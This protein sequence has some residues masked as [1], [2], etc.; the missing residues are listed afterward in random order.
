MLYGL[1]RSGSIE[2]SSNK[3][4][5]RLG[6]IHACMRT[7]FQLWQPIVSYE[8]RI[9]VSYGWGCSS[10]LLVRVMSIHSRQPIGVEYLSQAFPATASIRR[11]SRTKSSI[12]EGP[13]VYFI[14][15]GIFFFVL[16]VKKGN[17]FFLLKKKK[18]NVLRRAKTRSSDVW[19]DSRLAT[20]RTDRVCGSAPNSLSGRPGSN[21]NASARG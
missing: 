7:L 12:E 4:L 3:S 21:L 9:Y 19:Q 5:I 17:V 8:T 15:A 1:A 6:C 14:F 10:F 16:Y 20:R 2:G 13:T 11:F 18:E